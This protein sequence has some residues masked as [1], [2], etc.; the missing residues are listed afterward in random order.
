MEIISKEQAKANGLRY[1]F[2]GKPCNH[3]H[4]A[5]R[6]TSG[7]GCR[8]CLRG[9]NARYR[10]ENIDQTRERIADWRARNLEKL[11]GDKA[12]WF[13]DNPERT[14]A[15]AA[16]WEANNP[17]KVRAIQANWRNKNKDKVRDRAVRYYASKAGMA[18]NRKC[19]ASR[20]ARQMQAIPAW[21]GE[22]DEFVMAEAA[23]LAQLR[24]DATGVDWH[25]DH[26]VP[27]AARKAC[28]LHCGM[29]LQ[30]IPATLNES[31]HNK[32]ILT[33]P[34]EWLRHL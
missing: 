28:G 21:Y 23:L 10:R 6:M 1:Y 30:V 4:V 18:S 5:E 17:E 27:L 8:E 31:K 2:T 19:A 3:G 12:K 9:S 11:R 22:F 26:A 14:R 13:T 20:R 29:N 15:V 16:M 7:G 34:G 33:E 24:Q 32:M 25:V